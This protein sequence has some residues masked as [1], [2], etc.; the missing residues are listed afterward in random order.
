MGIDGGFQ[1]RALHR[2]CRSVSEGQRAVPTKPGPS[3]VVF[4]HLSLG[5][6]RPLGQSPAHSNLELNHRPSQTSGFLPH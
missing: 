6:Q 4:A 5:P 1:V 3:T 2:T